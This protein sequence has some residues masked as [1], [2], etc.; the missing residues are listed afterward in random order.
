MRIFGIIFY[1]TVVT[2][3]GL[4]LIFFAFNKLQPQEVA[5][6]FNSLQENLS[7]RM[8]IGLSGLVLIL[9]S[10][11]F[12]QII[13]G[14]FQREK[15]IAFPTQA[16]EVT[17]ALSAIEDLIRRLSTVLPEVKEL[18]PNVVAR[19]NSIVVDLRVTLRTGTSIPDLTNRLQDMVKSE[20][21]RLLG[22]LEQEPVV[23]MHIVKIASSEERD[24]K[25]KEF[26]KQET[27]IPF[28]GYGRV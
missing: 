8:I 16:G 26:E 28:G 17:V 7:S 6:L 4:A 3:I 19:K 21:E 5:D 27:T 10:F 13:L 11:S 15:T 22:T 24:R 2:L 14:K 23:N 12:A 1:S 9:I 25:K 18:R 20:I